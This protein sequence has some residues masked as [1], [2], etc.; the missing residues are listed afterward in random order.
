MKFIFTFLIGLMLIHFSSRAQLTLNSVYGN[1]TDCDYIAQGN[2]VVWWDNQN[3][4]SQSAQMLLDSIVGIEDDCLNELGMSLPPNVLD[5][6]YCNIYLHTTGDIYDDGW[7][8]GVGTDSN[9]YPFLT[10]P[11]GIENDFVNT[12]HEVFHLFQ[13]NANSPGFEYAG[14]S[15]WYI[16]ASA[17]WYAAIRN[18]DY[19][20]A[21]VEASSLVMNPQIPMWIGYDNMPSTYPENWQRYVHQYAMANFLFF[22]SEV[23]NVDR[24][25]ISEGFYQNTSL[26]PQEYLSEQI[27]SELYRSYFVDWAARIVNNFDFLT[28][29]Q[30]N[31]IWVEWNDYADPLDEQ[32][33][34]G[35]YSIDG[36]FGWVEPSFDYVPGPW[37][38]NAYLLENPV[39][40]Q[41]TFEYLAE[42]QGT[43]GTSSHFIAKVVVVEI[44][45]YTYH[46]VP[47]ASNFQGSLTIP[48][49]T[50]ADQVF[51]IVASTPSSFS[52]ST[53]LFNYQAQIYRSVTAGVENQLPLSNE[54]VRTYNLLGQEVRPAGQGL[55]IDQYENGQTLFRLITPKD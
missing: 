23:K 46:D 36:T 4:M 9:G 18:P 27:G 21:F 8:N 49:S 5:G 16:E 34:V 39:D 48:L 19:D 7:A 42:S 24:S 51:F 54:L 53:E 10:L 35:S 11:I 44:G 41:Y 6:Y 26:L 17:N 52:G 37:S 47:S 2:F 30:Q 13:Y 50:S 29:D 33:W 14:D 31:R 22:L 43:E 38:F 15:G 3:D 45:N 25:I 55:F 1:P 32:Q 28:T 20:A 12:C 40:D